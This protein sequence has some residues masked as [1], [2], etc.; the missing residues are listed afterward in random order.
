MN[1]SAQACFVMNEKREGCL[2]PSNKECFVVNEKKG[3][4][5]SSSAQKLG[6]LVSSIAKQVIA[7]KR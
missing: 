1:A 6:A 4:C 7:E 2:L 5:F 3:R